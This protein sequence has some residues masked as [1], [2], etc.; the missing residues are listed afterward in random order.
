MERKFSYQDFGVGV[1]TG[2]ALGAI[3]GI[4]LAPESGQSTRGRLVSGASNLKVSAQDLIDGAK[5]NL[6]LALNKLDGV[7]G[8]HEKH[9]KKRLGELKEELEQYNLTGA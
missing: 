9:V 3:A 7:F 5:D 8:S 6:E 2:L 4:L 1:L